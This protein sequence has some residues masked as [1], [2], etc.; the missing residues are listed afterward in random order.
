MIGIAGHSGSGKTTL[1]RYLSQQLVG[2]DDAVLSL[3]AYYRDRGRGRADAGAPPDVDA[4]GALDL[5]L[6]A[7]HLG[8]LACGRVIDRPEYDFHTHTR[9]SATVRVV[10]THT[11][12]I[13]GR[14]AFHRADVRAHFATLVFVNADE[15][16][17]LERRLRRD[18]R[19]RGRTASAVRRQWDLT[20][21]PMFTRYV[22]PTRRYAHL[23]VDGTQPI[24]AMAHAVLDHVARRPL[25]PDAKWGHG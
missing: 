18:T 3:D 7:N 24:E 13:E 21:Q 10:P 23:V 11:I 4:P 14:L 16:T 17:C 1:A 19:E 9:R 2:S 22:E 12:I 8:R 5:E 6:L 20:V 25:E 15:D